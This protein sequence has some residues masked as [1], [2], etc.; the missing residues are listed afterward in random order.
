[1]GGEI[2]SIIGSIAAI[3]T[4]IIRRRVSDKTWLRALYAETVSNLDILNTLDLSHFQGMGVTDQAFRE[5]IG[6]LETSVAEAV[7]FNDEVSRNSAIFTLLRTR[8][9][10]TAADGQSLSVER[11]GKEV[12]IPDKALNERIVNALFFIVTRIRLL[13]KLSVLFAGGSAFAH[14]FRLAVR[15]ANI[16]TRCG[17]IRKQLASHPAVQDLWNTD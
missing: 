17:M 5:I 14:D 9:G 3:G 7:L 12:D 11:E 15:L 8:S 10:I 1:M 2:G 16:K 6:A 13:K 4:G